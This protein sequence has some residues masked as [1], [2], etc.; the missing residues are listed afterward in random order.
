VKRVT[1]TVMPVEV[2]AGT[3]AQP[4]IARPLATKRTVPPSGI[5][6]TVALSVTRWPVSTRVEAMTSWVALPASAPEGIAVTAARAVVTPAPRTP[7]A[8]PAPPDAVT[9]GPVPPRVG[10]DGAGDV[11]PCPGHTSGATHDGPLGPREVSVEVVEQ[12]A[13]FFGGY[14]AH[15]SGSVPATL[16]SV[17]LTVGA[18]AQ[19]P[20]MPPQVEEEEVWTEISHWAPAMFASSVHTTVRTHEAD[21]GPHVTG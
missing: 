1:Q 14:P 7:V 20:G 11:D 10:G 8:P 5:G 6:V 16:V 2:L 13:G 17:E 19:L 18:T 12:M 21:V 9:E 4:G 15:V 3:A